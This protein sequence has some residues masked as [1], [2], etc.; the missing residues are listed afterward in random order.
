MLREYNGTDESGKVNWLR[1]YTIS[2]QSKLNKTSKKTGS[3][4]IG[5]SLTLK[6]IKGGRLGHLSLFSLHFFCPHP[7]I[8]YRNDPFKFNPTYFK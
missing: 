1:P 3:K 6:Q 8:F 2:E 5:L 4:R 7:R